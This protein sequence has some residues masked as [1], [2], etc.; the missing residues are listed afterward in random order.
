MTETKSS[1]QDKTASPKSAHAKPTSTTKT[2]SRLPNKSLANAEIIQ[3]SENQTSKTSEPQN[4]KSS[5]PK[6]SKTN[7]A[8][9]PSIGKAKTKNSSKSTTKITIKTS[10]TAEPKTKSKTETKTKLQSQSAATDAT[11][12]S[13][14]D[15]IQVK[16]KS[17]KKSTKI[18]EKSQESKTSK[19]PVSIQSPA[20][21]QSP[22]KTQ[23]SQ[24]SQTTPRQSS[25]LKT[26]PRNIQTTPERTE[27]SS[28]KT[29]STTKKQ[30]TKAKSKKPLSIITI[31]SRVIT[32]FLG[33]SSVFF[34][35]MLIYL[36]LLPTLYLVIV[37]LIITALT[38]ALGFLLWHRRVKS[39]IKVP[40]NILAIIFSCI[41]FIGGGYI[42]QASGFLDNLKP[43][44]YISEQYYLIVEKNSTYQ[45]AQDLANKTVGTFNEGIEIYQA[46]L[47]ELNS[48][49]DVQLQ[50]LDSIQS[51]T[52]NLLSGE[53]NAVFLSAVHKSVIDEDSSDFNQSTR[54]IST[55]EV[56]VKANEAANH[57]EVNVISEPF[58]VYISGNDSYGE[59]TARGRSD[60]NML[61]TVNP[62]THEIL[63]TSIPR[64]YYVQLH[65]T[66]GTKDKL[67]H[68]GIY[69]VTMSMQTLE[70]LLDIKIDYY[71]KVNFSTLVNL[72]DTIGGIDVYSDQRF[73]PWT[74]QKI[75][76]PEGNV[77]MDGAMA[78]AFARERKAYASGDRHRVQNQRDVLNAI[79]KKISSSAVI[80]TKTNDILNDLSNSLDTN[81]SKNEISS[82]VKLQLQDMPSWQI[83]EFSLNGG[84][85]HEFTYSFGSQP[86]YVMSPYPES[87]TAAHNYITGIL[88]GKTLEELNIPDQRQN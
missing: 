65:G 45:T 71:V 69:G 84:D 53:I 78:L 40:V 13:V 41:Y 30:P 37:T 57:P 27:T 55:I 36:N 67:T 75:V 3:K 12:E 62:V 70:D 59:L 5:S 72:V 87:I 20:K 81:V 80:L 56:K 60:V 28:A 66:T 14:P 32:V 50:N 6:S 61:A 10:A 82:L 19:I 31:F 43:Q 48:I 11:S 64:D 16:T 68:A 51:M 46:A 24:K 79:I 42:A 18:S 44:E 25:S 22:A 77:H 17:P 49:V 4:Q 86:L 26:K 2:K 34:I 29:T 7:T 52:N 23:S 54:I 76:I 63:L 85:A 39:A 8:P 38:G 33:L 47:K 88:A 73:I 35:A 58:T 15:F 21:V 74:N 9:K 83:G 1:N